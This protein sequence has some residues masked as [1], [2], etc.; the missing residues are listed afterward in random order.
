MA[1]NMTPEADSMMATHCWTTKNSP[2]MHTLMSKS[3][4]AVEGILHHWILDFLETGEDL[5]PS[6]LNANNENHIAK[7]GPKCG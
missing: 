4:S 3:T 7:M 5:T 6:W 1:K 2:S